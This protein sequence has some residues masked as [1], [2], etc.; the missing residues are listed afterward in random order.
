MENALL[1]QTLADYDLHFEEWWRGIFSE[2]REG[3]GDRLWLAGPSSY[4]FSLSGVRFAVDL[5]IRRAC[6][7]ER[8]KDTLV[9]DLSELSFMLIT[10]QHDDHFCIPLMQKLKD[11]N[12]HWYLP[13][14]CRAD[15]IEAS[16]LRRENITFL[17]AGDSFSVGGLTVR[18]FRSPHLGAGAD[19]SLFPELGYELVTSRGR[20]L[21]PADVRDYSFTDYPDFGEVDLCL[22]HLWGG[23]DALDAAAYGPM[24]DACADFFARFG[25][26]RYFFSHLYEIGRGDLYMWHE[27]HAA[28]VAEKIKARLAEA[29]T[30]VPEIGV[31]YPL[32]EEE[33]RKV[34]FAVC[35]DLHT[36][37]IH[38][39]PARMRAFLDAAEGAGCDFC[40]SL[41]DFC[42][43]GGRGCDGHKREILD[44]IAASPLPFYHA[45]GNHDMDENEKDAVL[46]FIGQ[47]QSYFSF[48]AGGVHFVVL[49]SCYFEDGTGD[50]RD[51]DHG[52]YKRT[53]SGYRIS[54]LPERELAWLKDDLAR[55]K[56][57]AVLFSHHSLIE[58]RASIGN[59]E[60]LREVIER[61]PQGVLLS[62]CGHE[63]VDRVEE[64]NGVYYACVNSM[65]YYWAGGAYEHSTYGDVIE[66]DFP[67]LRQVFPWRDALFAIVEIEDG[68]IR[69]RGVRS[70]IVGAEPAAL[71]FAKAGLV[72]PI[73]AEIADRVL[74]F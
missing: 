11:T 61:A 25:A 51:Y 29:C 73:V 54:V 12:I 3:D 20:V 32:F 39:A 68:E 47:E 7:L 58:S 6:D 4:V 38:D 59:C 41:G 65:A 67:L 8:V 57:P 24:L 63:H 72:D 19:Q 16:G 1:Y 28:I 35:A 14:G 56:F 40:V 43:P 74:P 48:D 70:E 52:D 66:R 9:E 30:A 49:D 33:K 64:K 22:A 69:L 62:L 10:H 46:D 71:N 36:E 37:F 53:P 44:M 17:R 55:T 2:Y 60:S 31:C 50:V 45:L 34:R 21:L 18:A 5:Q 23:N 27:G 42:P 15:L 13:E 26:K